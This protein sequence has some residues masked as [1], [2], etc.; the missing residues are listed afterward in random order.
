M[1]VRLAHQACTNAFIAA[2]AGKSVP[3]AGAQRSQQTS[4]PVVRRPAGGVSLAGRPS[5]ALLSPVQAHRAVIR[6][7][8]LRSSLLLRRRDDSNTTM[9]ASATAAADPT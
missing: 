3:D 8:M 6:A 1:H 7:R 2:G 5:H 9:A 4:T